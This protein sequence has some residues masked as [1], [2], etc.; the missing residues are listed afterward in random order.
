M[1]SFLKK[2]S[3]TIFLML[4]LT[5]FFSFGF[6]HLDKFETADEHLWKYGRIE[7]YWQ[8][9][10]EKNWAKTSINDKPGITVALISGIG[11]FAEPDPESADNNSSIVQ[12]FFKKYN[13]EE[14]KRINFYFRLPIL[15]FSTL[16]LLAFFFLLKPA[17]GSEK[18]ALLATILIG[19]NP[20]LIGISQIINPDSFFWIF[21][22]LTIVAYFAYLN[23]NQKK[24]LIICS[25]LMGFA[26]LSKYTSFILYA[27]FILAGTA[28]LIF[29]PKEKTSETTPINVTFFPNLIA[30]WLIILLIS[31]IVFA[32][33]LPATF[34][35]PEVFYTGIGQFL[36]SKLIYTGIIISML[37]LTLIF[38]KKNLTT[39][40]S[41]FLIKWQKL[42]LA[43]ALTLLSL[44]FFLSIFNL[45]TKEKLAPVNE[46]KNLAYANEPKKF[47]FKPLLDRKNATLH[48]NFK[49]LLMEAYPF[50]FSVSSLAIFLM[51]FVTCKSFR[52]KI[53]Y[54]NNLLLF[55]ISLF[56]PFY[57]FAT[58]IAKIVTNVR[59]SIVLYPLF[60]IFSA[61]ALDEL[62]KSINWDSK[63]KTSFIIIAIFIFSVGILWQIKPFY[64]NYENLLLPKEYSVHDTWGHGFYEAAQYLNSLEGAEN[65][66][67][68]SNS[69]SFCRYFNG[70][71]LRS[72]KIDLEKIQPDYLVVS[73]RGILKER[74]HFTFLNNRDKEKDTFY[75]FR[76]GEKNPFWELNINNRPANFIRI[77]EFEK[78][79]ENNKPN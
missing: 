1:L 47:N 63:K 70:Y 54:P 21:S 11:L 39:E 68:Y 40:I 15:I 65:F 38:W 6:Y 71:C 51:L 5:M 75:Y 25:I 32:L 72:R 13:P 41:T 16:S 61:I 56:I 52:Q 35:K 24:Y 62:L 19:L 29:P 28:K 49:L 78:T 3:T 7:Q 48:D 8:A 60:A 66:V 27:I 64:F 44:V 26:L 57:F 17:L 79:N 69:N 10:K 9:L 50:V 59:Y 36:T 37:F 42:F 74:N 23:T 55:T 46:L 30:S 76:K 22:G 20:I 14:T 4:T 67:V 31:T 58:L 43:G 53:S 77:I 73:T 34:V 2:Y 18:H 45:W 33:F 12:G